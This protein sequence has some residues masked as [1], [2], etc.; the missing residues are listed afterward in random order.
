MESARALGKGERMTAVNFFSKIRLKRHFLVRRL[1][2]IT[3]TT[4]LPS[5][6][7]AFPRRPHTILRTSCRPGL[8]GSFRRGLGRLTSAKV[9]CYVILSF[10]LR[11]SHLATGRFVAA[12][13]TSQLRISALLV[14]CSRHFKRGHRSNFRRCMACNRAY[15]VQIVGTS[16]CDRKR[17][18]IDSS[19]VQGLL[20]RYQIRRT[21]R[22]LACPCKLEKDVI[23]NCGI[24]QGLNFP[25]TGVRISRPFG[26]VPNVNMCTIQMCLGKRHCGKV[27]CVNG[28]PALSGKSGVALRMGVLGFSNSVCGGRVAIAFVRRMQNSVGFSALSRLVSRLGG[29][30]RAISEVLARWGVVVCCSTVSLL[31]KVVSHPSFDERRKRATSFLG[32]D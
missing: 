10:A 9:S 16:R 32:R 29:S 6:I 28:H 18:T 17:T 5:T 15:N 2:R 31:G 4:K 27:L 1:G 13:L 25:A 3:R 19:R 7:V 20:T 22:L 12:M 14:N 24:N 30:E 11:L 23:D 21:T 8:L 26:V